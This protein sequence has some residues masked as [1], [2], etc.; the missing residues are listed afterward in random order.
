[1]TAAATVL[2]L[3]AVS[4]ISVCGFPVSP[5]L[6]IIS[7]QYPFIK[8]GLCGADIFFSE[9]DF[10]TALGVDSVSKITITELPDGS[11]GTLKLG[12]LNVV[13]GQT[14]SAK[15]LSSLRFVPTDISEA[16]T[17]FSFCLTNGGCGA[18]YDCSIYT[19]S[20]V[21]SAPVIEEGEMITVGAFSG[22]DYFGSIHA[23]DPEND[24]MTFEILEEPSHGSV[25]LTN[26]D[27]GYYVYTPD[28][29]FSGVDSFTV[30]AF[31]KYGNY[32][33]PVSLKLKVSRADQEY[34]FA[35]MDGHWANSAVIACAQNRIIKTDEDSFRPDEPISRLEF[36]SLVMNAA[37]YAGFRASDT[38]FDDDVLIPAEYKGTVAIAEAEGIISG[39][40]SDGKKLFCPDNQITR[41]EAAVIVARLTDVDDSGEVLS[42]FADSSIPAWAASSMSALHKVGILRGD[43]STVSAYEPLT[44]GAAAQLAMAVMAAK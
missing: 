3:L 37:G 23:S 8:T 43:G 7:E 12:S 24:S 5:A 44:R 34:V 9:K 6:D 26:R 4:A 2:S 11:V 21:N 38:G 17:A 41:A 42:V 39:I 32:S 22:I 14:I 40:E 28:S 10:A 25:R 1:M 16:Q 15:N 31:D 19:L 18:S 27:A 33:S 29:D 30:C 36:L 20:S 35:D 13:E